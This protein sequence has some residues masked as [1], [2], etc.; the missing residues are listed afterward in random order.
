MTKVLGI[1]AIIVLLCLAFVAGYKTCELNP[2]G[3]KVV[4]PEWW[5]SRAV[6]ESNLHFYGI[7]TG[8][9][10]AEATKK[11]LEHAL[12]QY[13]L[14]LKADVDFIS[15]H[16]A[17]ETTAED[18][19]DFEETSELAIKV[20]RKG[21]FSEAHKITNTYIERVNTTKAL[22]FRAF[23]EIA[24][25]QSK[26]LKSQQDEEKALYQKFKASQAFKELEAEIGD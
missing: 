15:K 20:E 3:K 23:I 11:A 12:S 1:I 26:K 10:E 9:S 19:V 25:D 4:L 13:A 24:I 21:S 17:K 16:F 7:G 2:E 22:Q 18:N 8:E 6:T 5:D 14:Y